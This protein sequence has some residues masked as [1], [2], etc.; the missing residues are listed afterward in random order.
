MTELKY[1]LLEPEKLVETTALL[2]QRVG[3]RFPNAG[4]V[5]VATELNRFASEAVVRSQQIRQPYRLLRF[6]IGLLVTAIVAVLVYIGLQL[7]VK[8]EELLKLEQFVQ[9]LESGLGS[10]F[11][12]GATIVFLVTLE[13]RWKR[14]KALSAIHELRALA[15]IVDMHQLTKDP[16]STTRGGPRTPSSPKRNL[17]R[18]EL[19]RYL[20]YCSEMLSLISKIGA[21]YVQEFSDE[22]AL[23]A[24]DQLANLTGGLSQSI[25]QKIMLLDQNHLPEAVAQNMAAGSLALDRR[26]TPV[27]AD[28]PDAGATRSAP[29]TQPSNAEPTGKVPA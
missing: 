27:V 16:E 23:V 6:S 17:S 19:S 22:A 26:A 25:W 2:E 8:A 10:L 29:A 28:R 9:A 15:H 11:F 7:R 24:V 14:E 1:R 12:I 4:L 13:R 18:F 3:E 20:D 5:G 21:I